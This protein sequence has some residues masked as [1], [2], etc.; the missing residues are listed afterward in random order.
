[1]KNNTIRFKTVLLSIVLFLCPVIMISPG[2][3]ETLK[4]IAVCPLE[5]NATEDLSFLQNGL[6][7]MLSSRLTDPGKVEILERGVIDDALSKAQASDSTRGTLNESKAKLIGAD[8]GVDYVL[9]GSLTLFGKS[10]SLDT[11]LVDVTGDRPTLTFSRQAEEP[12][13]VITELDKIAAEIN[14]KTFGRRPELFMASEQYARRPE[15]GAQGA[16]YGGFL[17]NYRTLLAVSG[18]IIGMASGDVDGD[19]KNEVVVIYD[20]GIEILKDN[21]DGKLKSVKK[22]EDGHYM[23]IIGVDTA[24]INHN[25]T[26]E[27]FIS[28]VHPET[29][30]VKSYVLEY[31]GTDY[32]KRGGI[33]PWYLRVVKG[34]NGDDILYG[35]KSGKSGPYKGRNVFRVTWQNNA[36]VPGEKVSVPKGFSVLSLAAGNLI[37][38]KGMSALFTDKQGRLTIFDEM[39]KVEW[40]GDDAYGGSMLYY[41]FVEKDEFVKDVSEGRGAYFQPRNIIFDMDSDGKKDVIVIKNNNARTELFG[42]LRK[43]KSGSIEVLKWN[44]MGLSSE[45]TPKKIPGQITDMA[46]GNY[47]NNSRKELIVAIIKK[48]DNFSSKKSKSMIIAYDMK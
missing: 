47:D 30:Y 6:F 33:L 28:R 36:Y 2:A 15:M 44:E 3:C 38:G 19:N 42:Q 9:F 20:H 31:D 35:Q 21:L 25:G 41:T 4:K 40:S 27:I 1:L 46:V 7:S 8:L 32:K 37:G 45:N 39:G 22:I 11:T 17:T 43:F 5:M 13:A 10:V 12:G 24:D 14:F 29:G 16:G 26:A 34:G 23:N 48:R 18:E